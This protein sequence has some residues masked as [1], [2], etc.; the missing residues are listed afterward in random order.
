M[1]VAEAVV[2]P[3][4]SVAVD[5]WALHLPDEGP[6][7]PADEA[8]RLLGRRGLLGK[9]AAT[10]LALCAVHRALGLAVA[11]RPS[12]PPDPRTAV[13]ASSNLGNVATVVEV[14]RA[15]RR[16]G[17]REVS[18]ISA[19]ATSSNVVA[20]AV[21]IWFRAGGPSL[22]VCSGDGAGH[23]AV[24]LA[25]RLIRAG[26]ADR[27]IVVGAEPGDVEARALYR[28]GGTGLSLRAGAACV[29]L[30]S[31]ASASGQVRLSADHGSQHVTAVVDADDLRAAVGGDLYGA[32]GVAQVV[33][34]AQEAKDRSGP[35]PVVVA[36]SHPGQPRAWLL[37][38]GPRE[39]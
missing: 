31:G 15:V 10:R 33:V 25:T 39:R 7:G 28:R 16:G 12:G 17:R 27:V 35:D 24:L 36:V 30:G 4:W 14:V 5:G 11:E 37:L 32:A 21:A 22:M 38:L 26:R 23:D 9:D 18:P 34:G 2:R 29:V 8:P 1:R 6:D 13:V 19:P 20:S 3:S